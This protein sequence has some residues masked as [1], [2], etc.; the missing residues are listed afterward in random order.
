MSE[1]AM[2]IIKPEALKSF[3]WLQ[4]GD[5]SLQQIEEEV[6]MF[7]PMICREIAQTGMGSSKNYPISLPPRVNPSSLSLILDYC[8]FHQVP[9]RSNKERKSFDEKFVKIDTKQLCELTSAA[10][11][12]QLRP[13]V[14]LTSRALA[15]MI[16]GKTPEEIRETFHLP[17]D[18]TEEEKLEP[19]KN[20]TDDPRIRLLN[21]LYAKKRKELKERQKLQDVEVEERVDDRSVDD[22]LSF[23]NG[24]HQADSKGARSANKNKK[25]NRRRKDQS[26][27]SSTD[28]TNITHRKD[29]PDHSTLS[30]EVDVSSSN[31]P[32]RHPKTQESP[33][34]ALTSKI[35]FE[36]PDIDD[37]LDPEMKER[38]DKEVEDFARILNADWPERMQEILS[39]GQERKFVPNLMNG[40][41]SLRRYTDK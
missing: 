35:S 21:R 36:D 4:M 30:H 1:S 38:L 34:D 22:L 9:G 27:D 37:E 15:R 17:D 32:S 39:L 24:G 8:R 29:A 18:L 23:I 33:E 10:D 28:A 7:C 31:S 40:N 13:L 6:A 26:N 41:G 19:L 20:P 5:G 12:L 3:I 14:D 16:E 2:A 11:S 25:K